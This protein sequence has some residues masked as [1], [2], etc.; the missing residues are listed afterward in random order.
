MWVHHFLRS[1][2][3]K[4]DNFYAGGISGVLVK[5]LIGIL[6][7]SYVE[8]HH[9]IGRLT[10]LQQNIILLSLEP[11]IAVFTSQYQSR[12]GPFTYYVTLICDSSN[13]GNF[14]LRKICD[15]VGRGSEKLVF[16]VTE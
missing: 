10:F 7:I 12:M 9:S 8:S 6:V 5:K 3:K 1:S 11:A 16:C 2:L 4:K 14:Y 13:K 15:K